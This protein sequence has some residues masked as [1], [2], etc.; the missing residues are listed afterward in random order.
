MKHN[1]ICVTDVYKVKGVFSIT[2]YMYI[3]Y[4]PNMYICVYV[5]ICVCARARVCMCVYVYIYACMYLCMYLCMHVC[6]YVCV[7]VCVC[8]V[9]LESGVHTMRHCLND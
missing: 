4:R 8:M 9:H 3:A 7:C 5:C 1:Y 6:M 2:P